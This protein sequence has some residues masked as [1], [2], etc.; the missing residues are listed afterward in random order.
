MSATV[1]LETL[2]RHLAHI[3]YIGAIL[4]LMVIAATMAAFDAPAA[5]IFGMFTLFALLAGC[6]IIGPEF[7][8]GTLQLILSKP[9]HRS[10][11]LLS[12]VAGVALALWLAIAVIYG[13]DVTA[14]LL[15]GHSVSGMEGGGMAVAVAA[16]AALV[17]A[18]M[19][20]FGS[21]TRSYL[22]VALYIGGQIF[23]SLIEG[24]LQ[25]IERVERGKFAAL[26]AFLRNHPG[27]SSTFSTIHENI[28]PTP[29]PIPF[30]RNWLLM[31][32]TNAAVALLLA[33]LVFRRREVPYGAD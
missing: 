13:T 5:S 14:R 10:R 12:R 11:Y 4:A 9:I 16:Q 30:D 8:R 28:Y 21:F 1:I 17:C 25:F 18:L 24:V 26:G 22:N 7:S 19:A 23:L 27:V 20:L 29:P 31:V 33:C 32:F 3:A 6:Q 2:R 15:A